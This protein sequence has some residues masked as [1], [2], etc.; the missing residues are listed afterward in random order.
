MTS[1]NSGRKTLVAANALKKY[2]VSNIT[3]TASGLVNTASKNSNT[4]TIYVGFTDWTTNY[5]ETTA[6]KTLTP[7]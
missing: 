7:S 3:I 6:K 5:S 1:N 4:V 2:T